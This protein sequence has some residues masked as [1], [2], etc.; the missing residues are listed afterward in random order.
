MELE[1]V[2]GVSVGDLGL[3]IGWQIDDVDCSEWAFL[4]ADTATNAQT[5]GDE[6]NLGGIFDFD[7]ETA[8]ADDR[9]GFLALLSTFLRNT[10][11]C[12]VFFCS[13]LCVFADSEMGIYLWFALEE[14]CQS[15]IS[16]KAGY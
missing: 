13:V 12:P 15:L 16:P 2:G 14:N 9:A 4:W 3:E 8:T 7:T 10:Q 11:H 5:F 1:A 6:G